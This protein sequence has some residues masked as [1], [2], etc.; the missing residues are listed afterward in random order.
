MLENILCKGMLDS[1]RYTEDARSNSYNGVVL[2]RKGVK[3]G[4]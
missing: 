3:S 2:A 1:H 4:P